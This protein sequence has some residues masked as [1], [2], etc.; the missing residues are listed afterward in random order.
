MITINRYLGHSAAEDCCVPPGARVVTLKYCEAC[1]TLF[2]RINRDRYCRACHS[3]PE[4]L[5][6][7]IT[8]AILRELLEDIPLSQ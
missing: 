8:V 7:N 5:V 3:D 1:G 2:S 4:I 6:K